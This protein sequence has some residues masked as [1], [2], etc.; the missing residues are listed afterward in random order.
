[1]PDG[2][3][4]RSNRRRLRRVRLR[5]PEHAIRKV[6]RQAS[7]PG[8]KLR[9]SRSERSRFDGRA[10]RFRTI[11]AP[12]TSKIRMSKRPKPVTP[13]RMAGAQRISTRMAQDKRNR[14]QRIESWRRKAVE[15]GPEPVE[16][17]GVAMRM[18][19]VR[20]FEPPTPASRTQYSTRLSYT[21]DRPEA[22]GKQQPDALK[23]MQP[24]TSTTSRPSDLAGPCSEN[25]FSSCVRLQTSVNCTRESLY[26]ELGKRDNASSAS[27]D[28][29]CARRR[30]SASASVAR[31]A[32]I[33]A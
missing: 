23:E 4:P 20:G 7:A 21:P 33:T 9:S 28:S 11:H 2:Y 8:R 13:L 31:I 1:M 22:R 29:A 32:S 30:A 26:V 27:D 5:S 17:R 10:T 25:R 3:A 18:V 12:T 24:H 6:R 15:P 19:G 14:N 16:P